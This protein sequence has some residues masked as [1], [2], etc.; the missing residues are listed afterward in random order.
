MKKKEIN[1]NANGFIV[2]RLDGDFASNY[3][4]YMGIDGDVWPIDKY[5]KGLNSDD[6]KFLCDYI[7]E[8][9]TLSDFNTTGVDVC[10]DIEFLNMYIEACK[11]TDFQIEVLF[12]E[13]EKMTPIYEMNTG[14][15]K[16]K[17]KFLGF[18]YGYPGT[19]YYS[20]VY[21]DVKTIPE[22]SHM[23]L[24]KNGLFETEKE[25]IEFILIRD[26]LKN[27]LPQNIFEQGE[28]IIYK[29]WRYI[30]EYPLKFL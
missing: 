23:T 11:K 24:N 27:V 13:T 22:M 17:F 25:V 12:C 28:F 6:I 19:D 4:N 5:S 21:S 15:I 2:K 29:L 16:E 26:K 8:N 30:G 9:V 7:D 18:D 3:K 20:C 10:N 14:N 1:Y